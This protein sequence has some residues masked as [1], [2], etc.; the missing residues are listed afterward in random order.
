MKV[1]TL[2]AIGAAVFVVIAWMF[3]KYVPQPYMDEIFHIPQTQK[4]CGGNFKEWDNMITTLPGLYYLSYLYVSS[5]LPLV[6]IL[7]PESTLLS[8]CTVPV[9]RSVNIFLSFVNFVLFWKISLHLSPP[10]ERKSEPWRKSV[11]MALY[12]LQF[13][14]AFLFY[15]D[16]GATTAVLGMY[17]FALKKKSFLS[18]TVRLLPLF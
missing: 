8:L 10:E 5:L 7:N 18:A 11:L 1:V 16:I 14:F 2:V 6:Q 9:L 4:Y 17:F 13:F 3:E 15:T 12:P